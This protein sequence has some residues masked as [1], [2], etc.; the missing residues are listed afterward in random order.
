MTLIFSVLAAI[1]LFLHGLASFSDEVT[2]LGGQ[3]LQSALQRL[4]RTDIQA[5]LIGAI[6]TAI[7][8]SSSA[9]TA[10]ATG[11]AHKHTLTA[12][13]AFAV[14]IGANVGTTF[15]A[16]L[17]TFEIVGLGPIFVAIGGLF[18]FIGPKDW[19]SH[20]KALFYFGLV[21]LALDLISQS[22]APIAENSA[23]AQ[24]Q[25]L[26]TN[27]VIA[28]FTAAI[29][30]A[31]VQSSSVVTGVAVLLVQKNILPPEVA[32]WLVA[33]A[34]IGTTSTALLAGAVLD[35]TA[36]KLALLNTGVN[37]LGVLLFATIIQ[38]LIGIVIGLDI[39][40]DHKVA[41][42]HTLFNVI[43]AIAAL[44]ILP[45]IWPLLERWL[46]RVKS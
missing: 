22:L 10:M 45:Y 38:P 24:W 11:L 43:A 39:A 21:F 42:V 29:L 8:Q 3:R 33:G 7:V 20:G 35:N 25:H 34:N 46:Y 26:L 1:M 5:A 32:V 36:R 37:I 23:L 14:M 2:R 44:L 28:I 27:P 15:T 30:T 12:R 17:V 19:R 40:A 6:S 13:G 41:I 9:V 31:L 18:S 16:W 4:T